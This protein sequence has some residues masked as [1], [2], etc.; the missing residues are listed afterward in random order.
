MKRTIRLSENDLSRLI[1]RIVREQDEFDLKKTVMDTTGFE[2]EDIP[3]ECL[4]NNPGMSRIE[5]IQGCI[6]KITDKSTALNNAIKALS[7]SLNKAKS[8]AGSVQT[9]SRRRR[10]FREQDETTKLS[11]EH[12]LDKRG[13][14]TFLSGLE[15]LVNMLKQD[16]PRYSS[17][18]QSYTFYDNILPEF[19]KRINTLFM[20]TESSAPNQ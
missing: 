3:Q 13:K 18:R 4:G 9:E 16:E 8:E 6:T 10:M 17:F 15:S 14:E 2:E 5:M 1:K 7:D 12:M 19:K 20:E 11:T